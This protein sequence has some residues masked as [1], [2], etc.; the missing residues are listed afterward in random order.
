LTAT[1]PP[2]SHASL[3]GSVRRMEETAA[4]LDLVVGTII[5]TRQSR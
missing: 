1:L 2:G 3:A 4:G 5:A